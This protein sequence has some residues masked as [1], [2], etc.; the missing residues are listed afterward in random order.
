MADAR[1]AYQM[2]RFEWALGVSNL[3][4]QTYYTQAYTCA[5]NVTTDI[6]PEPGRVVQASLKVQF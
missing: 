5:G 1:Y 6:Y 2:G 3:M 4:D